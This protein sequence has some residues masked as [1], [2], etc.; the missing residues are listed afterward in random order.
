[1]K[2][3]KVGLHG[4]SLRKIIFLTRVPS[5]SPVDIKLKY[6]FKLLKLSDIRICHM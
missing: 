4:I 6:S 5:N 1:M 3:L 2:M